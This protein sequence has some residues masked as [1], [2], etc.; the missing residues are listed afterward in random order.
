M[1]LEATARRHATALLDVVRQNRTEDRASRDLS[2]LASLVSTHEEL[3]KALDAPAVAPARK[4]AAMD[5]LMKAA[6]VASDEVRRLV[7]LLADRGRLSMLP[8]VSTAFQSLLLAA[9]RAVEAE[10]VTTLPLP[11]KNQ[12]ALA[13][14]LSRALD[15][16][17]TIAARQDPAIMGGVRARVGSI[18]YDGTIAGQLERLRQRLVS[19]T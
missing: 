18:V 5:A 17:V 3:R 7:D 8:H 13:A 16:D 10:V 4:K 6:G 11:E 14:A 12:Q 9:R 15:A 19:E 1:S 2:M